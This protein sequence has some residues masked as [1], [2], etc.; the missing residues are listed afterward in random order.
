M[1]SSKIEL[2]R[3]VKNIGL[4]RLTIKPGGACNLNCPHCH[5]DISEFEFNKDIIRFI[6]INPIQS[7][8]FSGGEPL[9]YFPVIKKIAE[10]IGSGYELTLVSNGS[11]LT[12]EIVDFFNEF[13][14]RIWLSYDGEKS[15]RDMTEPPRYSKLRRLKHLGT[16]NYS[17]GT[18]NQFELESDISGFIHKYQLRNLAAGGGAFL[19]F[20]HET[21]NS[22]KLT[23]I[24]DART[25]LK[26]LKQAF[27]LETIKIKYYKKRPDV[28]VGN[29]LRR[30]WRPKTYD[31]GFACCNSNSIPMTISGKFLRCSYENI[32]F[33]DIY[34]GV[35]WGRLE[36]V[37][38]DRCKHCTIWN[39]CKNTCIA[40]VGICECLISKE[41]HNFIGRMQKKYDIDFLSYMPPE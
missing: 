17:S 13:D 40:N 14:F 10:E 2:K 4:R 31:R 38:P 27:E 37:K 36:A 39:I 30:W 25:Y 34:S 12:N 32:F 22:G 28:I 35:D 41:M 21:N 7:I 6:K 24:E 20:L 11:L 23:T 29:S 19:H 16:S 3:E 18:L 8:F 5:A 9:M 33:G 15:Q 26:Y 1:S